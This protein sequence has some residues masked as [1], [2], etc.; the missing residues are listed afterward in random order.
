MH[1][2]A[3]VLQE[4]ICNGTPVGEDVKPGDDPAAPPALATSSEPM[5]GDNSDGA[6][7]ETTNHL[8]NGKD[9]ASANGK[10][11]ASASGEDLAS[12]SG[13]DLASVSRKAAID[14]AAGAAQAAA[15]ATGEPAP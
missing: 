7:L 4:L 6:V 9:T 3:C 14:S 10:D 13:K 8:V 12:V 15:L 1:V 5:S 11:L 2:L